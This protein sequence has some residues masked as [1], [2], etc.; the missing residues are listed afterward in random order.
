[1]H[2]RLDGTGHKAVVDEEVLLNAELGVAAFEVAI[3]VVLNTMAQHQVLSARGGADRVGLDETEPLERAFQRSGCEKTT[4]DRKAAQV[5]EGDLNPAY[6]KVIAKS[7]W[8]RLVGQP[9]SICLLARGL[10]YLY[11]HSSNWHIDVVVVG[12][13]GDRMPTLIGNVAD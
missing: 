2:E 7:G 3:T 4:G 5:I 9:H 8:G 6:E 11:A 13:N 1:M 10:K 12:I